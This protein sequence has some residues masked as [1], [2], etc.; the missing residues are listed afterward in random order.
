[1]K[2]LAIDV[3]TTGLD[4]D[5]DQLIEVGMVVDNLEHQIPL[6]ELPRFHCYIRRQQY[7]GDPYALAM[8]SKILHRIAVQEVGWQYLLEESVKGEIEGFL[9][10]HFKSSG[11]ADY[12]INVAGKNYGSFDR[13]FLGRLPGV[14]KEGGKLKICNWVLAARSFDPGSFMWR[15]GDKELP[16]L[17]TCYERAGV[18]GEVAHTAVE[19]CLGVVKLCRY[20]YDRLKV[21]QIISL[22]TTVMCVFMGTRQEAT[23][24]L[25]ELK[26]KAIEAQSNIT[27]TEYNRNNVWSV[28]S[29]DYVWRN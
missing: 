2:Y 14:R 20:W 4:L 8:H 5:N 7:I 22:N 3:E 28:Q 21:A 25:Y 12:R 18:S 26:Q 13:Y 15:P 24:K 23:T 1:M 11:T 6:E 10:R 17:K 16:N 19:D 29:V 27:L 9:T